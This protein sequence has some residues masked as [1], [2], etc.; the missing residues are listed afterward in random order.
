MI[1]CRD[2]AKLLTSDEL[3]SQ[4]RWKRLE[5]RLHLRMCDYCT[6]LAR[7]IERLRAAARQLGASDESLDPDLEQRIIRKLSSS[8]R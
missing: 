5:V 8:G 3:V 6:R 1:S 4:S 7:Q 2:V